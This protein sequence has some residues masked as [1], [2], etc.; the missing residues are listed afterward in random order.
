MQSLKT[1]PLATQVSQRER[2][3]ALAA[4][5]GGSYLA[6]EGRFDEHS[7]AASAFLD[8]IHNSG[9]PDGEAHQE[10]RRRQKQYELEARRG[11]S[12]TFEWFRQL[13]PP[14]G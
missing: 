6:V 13:E 8:A 11:T 12:A 2:Y 3:A 4:A 7:R 1:A 14:K 10:R 9:R 5:T